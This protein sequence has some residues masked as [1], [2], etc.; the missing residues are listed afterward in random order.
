[1]N[2]IYHALLFLLILSFPGGSNYLSITLPL[3]SVFLF[4]VALVLSLIVL[5]WKKKI[6]FFEGYFTKTMMLILLF[7]LGYGLLGFLWAPQL[8][9]ALKDWLNLLKGALIFLLVVSL[10]K[11]VKDGLSAIGKYWFVS[12]I[13]VLLIAWYEFYFNQHL[14][15]HFTDLLMTLKTYRSTHKNLISVFSGPNELSVFLVLSLPFMLLSFKRNMFLDVLLVI[16][17][18]Y[19]IWLNDSKIVMLAL[20]LEFLVVALVM[21]KQIYE[22]VVNFGKSNTTIV[23]S[24]TTVVLFF[25]VLVQGDFSAYPEKGRESGMIDSISDDINAVLSS[26]SGGRW[27]DGHFS[28]TMSSRKIRTALIKNGLHFTKDS[29]LMGTG[30][31]GFM[32]K[33]GSADRVYFA[34]NFVNPHAWWIEILS[35]Y[36]AIVF[37]LYFG[38]MVYLLWYLFQ[39]SLHS[40]K[41]SL[42][43]IRLIGF[44]ASFTLAYLLC[45]N[46]SSSFMA[47]PINWISLAII[48][49]SADKLRENKSLEAHEA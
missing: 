8:S 15:S 9:A 26:A 32:V 17:T 20:W 16:T 33:M 45:S 46:S 14:K 19:L 37:L 40:G 11:E 48:A 34:D 3:G 38:W 42:P 25:S 39:S 7:W 24:I 28:R 27:T 13:L 6:V 43:S 12:L 1:M 49:I 21:R 29:Y 35:Q 2:R 36:G 22:T 4:R 10:A 18:V 44:C 31:G 30:P 5:I 47:L 23:V 41:N